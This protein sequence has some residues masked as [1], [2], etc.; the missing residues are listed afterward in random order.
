MIVVDS[1]VVAYTFLEGVHT[2]LALGV[3]ERDPEWR[4][5]EL[6]RHEYLNILATY[7]KHGAVTVAVAGRLWRQATHLLASFTRPVDMLHALDLAARHGISAYDAQF[8]ALAQGLGIRCVTE[9]RSLLKAFP[10]VAVSMRAFC[11][12]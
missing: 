11:S 5:P 12:E 1:N 7:V 6:W 4:L 3:R 10:G 2:P 8:L 9:D